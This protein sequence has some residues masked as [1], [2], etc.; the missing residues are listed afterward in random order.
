MIRREPMYRGFPGMYLSCPLSFPIRAKR[1]VYVYVAVR[2]RVSALPRRILCVTVP[3]TSQTRR[4][5]PVSP[6][7][8]SLTRELERLAENS[9]AFARAASIL[10]VASLI[11]LTLAARS[12][13]LAW[14][15]FVLS[16]YC[17]HVRA[18]L[19]LVFDDSSAASAP[20][21][22]SPAYGR[23]GDSSAR[24]RC[25]HSGAI[26][27]HKILGDRVCDSVGSKGL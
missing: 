8:A 20:G 22:V 7:R 2:V 24:L 25:E 19:R 13:S 18:R 5:G 16:H 27:Q 10:G 12:A 11:S 14:A 1:V 15:T 3:V 6:R 4:V 26:L 23:A 9:V 21:Y 17:T